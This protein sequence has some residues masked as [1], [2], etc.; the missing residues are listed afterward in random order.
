M[1]P[2][3]RQAL[4]YT[5]IISASVRHAGLG[6]AT[7]RRGRSSVAA[8][9]WV[10][11]EA[12]DDQRGDQRDRRN[13]SVHGPSQDKPFLVTTPIFYVNGPPHLGHCYTAVVADAVARWARLTNPNRPVLLQ[14][15]TDEH[16][17]KIA[18]VR[19][20]LEE[21]GGVGRGAGAGAAHLGVSK[22]GDSCF[23]IP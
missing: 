12:D 19:R 13:D 14:T 5:A 8:A 10:D 16:G 22:G 9:E 23:C 1:P 17:T 15:G 11:D 21:R 20:F 6:A 3:P 7:A 2:L 18:E 4:G